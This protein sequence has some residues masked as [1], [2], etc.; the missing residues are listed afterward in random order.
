MMHLMLTAKSFAGLGKSVSVA[1]AGE[2][3][4]IKADPRGVTAVWSEQL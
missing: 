2:M 4:V 1:R 3:L